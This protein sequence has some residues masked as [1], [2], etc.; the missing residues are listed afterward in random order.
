MSDPTICPDCKGAMKPLFTG[1]YCPNNCDKPHLKA[2]AIAKTIAEA[3]DLMAKPRITIKGN[4]TIA[5]PGGGVWSVWPTWTTPNTVAPMADDQ[6]RHVY[7]N[8]KGKLTHTSYV[9]GSLGTPGQNFEHYQCKLCNRTWQ[10]DIDV[11]K[12]SS[13]GLPH[14][15]TVN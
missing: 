7:C 11:A 15:V 14:V 1:F 12:A 13:S 9:A 5:T 3:L 6:C 2:A 4:N 10:V 8:G